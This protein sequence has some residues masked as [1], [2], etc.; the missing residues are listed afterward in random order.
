MRTLGVQVR[1]CTTN[2]EAAAAIHAVIADAAGGAVAIDTETCPLPEWQQPVPIELTLG[3][4]LIKRMPK[5]DDKPG[6]DPHR[7]E[8]RLVQAYGGGRTVAVVDLLFVSWNVLEP[9]WRLPLVAHN[10][11]F[12]LKFL[13]R[14][15]IH[16]DLHDTE[17]AARLLQGV[18]TG[19]SGSRGEGRIWRLSELAKEHLSIE[20]SKALQRSDW[21]P[22][23]LSKG[24]ICYSAADAVVTRRV[25][26]RMAPLLTDLGRGRAYTLQKACL[27]VAAA[28]TL[29][30]V[31][32]DS[33]AHQE[34]CRTLDEDLAK[35]RRDW[36]DATGCPPST[37]PADIISYITSV[38][39]PEELDRWPKTKN[40]GAL[41]CTSAA[42]ETNAHIPGLRSLLRIQYA[43]KR[44]STFGPDL[45]R[46]IN[47]I[48]GR[49]HPQYI[50]S[51][52]KTGRWSARDPAIQQVPKNKD[53]AYNFRRIIVAG[54]D[55]LLVGGDY[56][57]M[58]LR[59]VAALSGDPEMN[60][61][62]EAG[63]D[64]HTTVAEMASGLVLS[65]LSEADRKRLRD[66]AKAVNFG[67]IYGSGPA[68]LAASALNNYGVEMS[69]EEAT[70]LRDAIFERFPVRRRWAAGNA[71]KF[72][73][74][75]RITIGIGRVIEEDW[76]I[77]EG[78][79]RGGKNES[80]LRWTLCHNAPVQGACADCLMRAV[81][82]I[83]ERMTG[84]LVLAVHDELVVEVQ[85]DQAE[86]A[87]EVLVDAMT[88]AFAVTFPTVPLN[89]L[90][91]C[92]IGRSWADVH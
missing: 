4:K 39:S 12:E 64:L 5:E 51:G 76:E 89:G 32:F 84:T 2:D 14:R 82:S 90:V 63:E 30:G 66:G 88:Q 79:C 47:P 7:S 75:G 59:A 61:A 42:L 8:I 68:G 29:R 81:I 73:K 9:L 77:R 92:K 45:L 20:M 65:E 15:G 52:A 1:Y 70:E 74:A 85:E 31:G 11:A 72:Q 17:Q 18:R 33:A 38:L 58:E 13:A 37:K 91:E 50:V 55:H 25:W 57:A 44:L 35:A 54:E 40:T 48:T 19:H 28:M 46:V 22:I 83:H 49:L 16:P 53:K 56:S 43:E 23:N 60:L 62:F 71:D 67:V 78:V 3:G 6:V 41:S 10:A 87:R 26:Q 86:H 21:G 24:Q 34:L 69:L 27:P 36:V 80:A